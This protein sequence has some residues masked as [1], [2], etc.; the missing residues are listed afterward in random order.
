LSYLITGISVLFE[1]GKFLPPDGAG[2]AA[3]AT[4][5]IK[6]TLLNKELV[7]NKGKGLNLFVVQFEA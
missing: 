7:A 6:R 3:A 4:L 5:C 2:A 1:I